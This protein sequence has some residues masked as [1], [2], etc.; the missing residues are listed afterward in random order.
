MPHLDAPP[1][2]PKKAMG[3]EITSAH[4]QE[5]TRN[6]NALYTESLHSVMPISDGLDA[7]CKIIYNKSKDKTIALMSITGFGGFYCNDIEAI[8]GSEMDISSVDAYNARFTKSEPTSET[9]ITEITY[10]DKTLISECYEDKDGNKRTAVEV[11]VD[12][13]SF[14]GGKT[15]NA[16]NN[17]QADIS[18]P[19]VAYD[20]AD[21]INDDLPF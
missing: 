10:G 11:V 4:G 17:T 16:S 1:I 21:A 8:A 13:A 5:M 3:T 18:T 9:V 7:D 6:I 14:C 20:E 2:P 12:R 15:E 19:D